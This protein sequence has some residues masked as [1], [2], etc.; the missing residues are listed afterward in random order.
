M[1]LK[2]R[3][4]RLRRRRTTTPGAHDARALAAAGRRIL[5]LETAH[6]VTQARLDAVLRVHAH[7]QAYA[8]RLRDALWSLELARRENAFIYSQQ[9][10]A[11]RRHPAPTAILPAVRDCEDGDRG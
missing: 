6:A 7:C 5:Q 1:H 3:F 2:I 9:R 8:P 11:A 10:I 4:P